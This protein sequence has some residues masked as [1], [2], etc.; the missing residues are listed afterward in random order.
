MKSMRVNIAHFSFFSLQD[1]IFGERATSFNVDCLDEILQ[2][3]LKLY[4]LTLFV[5][6]QLGVENNGCTCGVRLLFVVFIVS[7]HSVDFWWSQGNVIHLKVEFKSNNMKIIWTD[8]I[9][10][11][12]NIAVM[13]LW[14]WNGAFPKDFVPKKTR[15]CLLSLVA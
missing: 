7:S 3:A 12:L 9:N 4:V 6:H 2:H 1:K 13:V 5:W 14:N 11:I 10:F 15:K 8:K